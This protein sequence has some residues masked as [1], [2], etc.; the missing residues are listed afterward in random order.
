MLFNTKKYFSMHKLVISG[1]EIFEFHVNE[2][3]LHFLP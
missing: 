1:F 2:N 3:S